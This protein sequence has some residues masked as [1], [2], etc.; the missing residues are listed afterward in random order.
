MTSTRREREHLDVDDAQRVLQGEEDRLTILRCRWPY[1]AA[2]K[3]MPHD[4]ASD[5]ATRGLLLPSLRALA[6]MDLETLK[7]VDLTFDQCRNDEVATAVAHRHAPRP[8]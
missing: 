8:P 1:F 2:R 5:Q 3:Q 7:D 4:E 6:Q